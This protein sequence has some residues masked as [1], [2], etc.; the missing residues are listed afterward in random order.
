MRKYRKRRESVHRLAWRKMVAAILSEPNTATAPAPK[1][2]VRDF[3]YTGYGV[4]PEV[5]RIFG[6]Q[7]PADRPGYVGRGPIPKFGR[8]RIIH[9][10]EC[11]FIPREGN[12]NFPID[13][14][15]AQSYASLVKRTAGFEFRTETT[16]DGLRIY[17]IA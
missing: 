15:N 9:V 7:V 17:R 10:G 3:I 13:R 5:A 1:P 6:D 11:L 14:R 2:R 12:P 16:D 8:L 4:R